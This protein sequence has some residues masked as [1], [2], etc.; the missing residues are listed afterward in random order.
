MPTSIQRKYGWRRDPF[1]V[2]NLKFVAPSMTLARMK[3]L[4]PHADL[5]PAM[6]VI[7]DQ[8]EL[9]SCTANALAGCVEYRNPGLTSLQ[10][11]SRLFIY[12]N[13]RAAQGQIDSDS[14]STISTGIDTLQQFGVCRES[15]WPYDVAT[16]TAEPTKECYAN[17]LQDVLKSRVQVTTLSQIK[18]KVSD[19][20]PV[21]FG[22]DVYSSFESEEVAATGIVPMPTDS[23]TCVGGHAVCA[24]GYD[25]SKGVMIVRNSWGLSWGMKG[26][27]TLPYAYISNPNLASDFWAIETMS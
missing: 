5:R 8:G 23:D 26:Y 15:E 4:P 27:F 17:A 7:Y 21:A 24:V 16:Y 13:E 18:E 6:P 11:P 10:R 20:F 25:D 9:G 2:G 19:N 12:Y 22:F 3:A 1:I 14:G